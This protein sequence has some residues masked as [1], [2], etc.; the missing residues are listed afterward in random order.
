MKD[1]FV[2][3]ID[4]KYRCKNQAVREM[5]DRPIW[6]D[7]I[8]FEIRWMK[9]QLD[10]AEYNE[11]ASH[12]DSISGFSPDALEWATY[13]D[14][15]L[16]PGSHEMVALLDRMADKIPAKWHRYLH[17]GLTSSNVIDSCNHYRWNVLIT[18]YEAA[19]GEYRHVV[20]NRY[21]GNVAFTLI[22]GFT[23]GRRAS[24][25]TIMQRI[26]CDFKVS[27]PFL[28]N[29]VLDEVVTG[30]PTGLE[31][32]DHRQAEYRFTYWPIWL[33]LAQHSAAIDQVAYDYR[34]Y[35]SDLFCGVIGCQAPDQFTVSSAMPSK[36]NPSGFEQVMSIGLMIRGLVCNLLQTPP[37]LLDRDLVHSA[38]ERDTIPRLWEYAF[39]QVERM[40][41]LVAT[42]NL[43]IKPGVQRK[44]SEDVMRARLD[45]GDDWFTARGKAS[46]YPA[47]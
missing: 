40:T 34:L 24:H 7:W 35:C 25:T 41:E 45:A 13:H 11:F 39:Y 36:R 32:S 1:I 29:E 37:F 20:G 10:P 9:R 47:G 27:Q 16:K 42:T 33:W 14:E 17:R 12:F 18:A 22:P 15:C 44:L 46:K 30:G 21:P 8:E 19:I 38:L 4:S 26:N 5:F 28:K 6:H 23:H 43:E 2:W 31:H 3:S